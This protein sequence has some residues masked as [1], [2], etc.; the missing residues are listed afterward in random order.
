MPMI[1]SIRNK[2]ADIRYHS[3]SSRRSRWHT[4][5]DFMPVL[6]LVLIAPMTW[7]LDHIYERAH[8]MHTLNGYVLSTAQDGFIAELSEDPD[9]RPSRSGRLVCEFKADFALRAAGLPE[10]TSIV[11]PPP[12]VEVGVIGEALP[13]VNVV[14]DNDKPM[15]RAIIDLLESYWRDAGMPIDLER[16]GEPVRFSKRRGWVTNMVLLWIVMSVVGIGAVRICR[17]ATLA[18]VRRR[19]LRHKLRERQNKC[20][21]CGYDLTGLEFNERCPECGELAH[22]PLPMP[23]S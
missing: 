18:Y 15:E 21:H 5:I 12:K 6:A 11:L 4:A 2:L 16:G 14:L 23:P 8:Q 10:P 7:L 9:A 22:A 17:F 1:S 19:Y 3:A 13:R 20:G